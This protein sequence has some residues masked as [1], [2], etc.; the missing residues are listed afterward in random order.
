M[1]EKTTF[2]FPLMKP[3]VRTYGIANQYFY[4]Y[5]Q[6]SCKQKIFTTLSFCLVIAE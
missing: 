3:E 4:Q 2:M 6:Y 5:C 1:K